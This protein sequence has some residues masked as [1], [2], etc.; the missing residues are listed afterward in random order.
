MRRILAV[1]IAA[2]LVLPPHLA[3]AVKTG[4]PMFASP[5]LASNETAT[6][7]GVYVNEG[8]DLKGMPYGGTVEIIAR[9]EPLYEL[10]FVNSKKQT[11][12]G[13][14]LRRKDEIFAA[15]NRRDCRVSLYRIDGSALEGTWAELKSKTIGHE[16]ISARIGGGADAMAGRFTIVSGE[17]P[18]G[19]AYGGTG[20]FT[21][22]SGPTDDIYYTDHSYDT[23]TDS[24]L[25]GVGFRDRDR[26][27]VA[28]SVYG[29]CAPVLYQI[30]DRGRILFVKYGDAFTPSLGLGTGT[31]Y[32]R[33]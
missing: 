9:D 8:I 12:S 3:R 29:G 26:L 6:I 2:L 22:V 1:A 14:A 32:R 15:Y 33:D 11:F 4:V 25:S 23:K 19:D 5:G 7:T 21:R 20:R 30:K 18:G 16:R 28:S 24:R 31:L 10:V 27:I 13:V 17:L